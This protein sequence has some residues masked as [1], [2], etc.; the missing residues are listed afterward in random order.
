MYGD[1]YLLWNAD[2]CN[3]GVTVFSMTNDSLSEDTSQT[4][5]W[6]DL[7][8]SALQSVF[9]DTYYLEIASSAF[10]GIVIVYVLSLFFFSFSLSLFLTFND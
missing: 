2:I 4:T 3:K 1:D 5:F 10:S 7:E 6:K 8:V 9:Q